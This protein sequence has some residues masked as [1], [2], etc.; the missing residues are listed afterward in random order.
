MSKC[1]VTNKVR[2]RDE[3]A[4]RE[5]LADCRN[6]NRDRVPERYYKCPHC[7]GYHLT[8]QY[9]RTGTDAKKVWNPGF[10]R[11]LLK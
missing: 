7:D 2:Y 11:F 9:H 5:G 3:A 6:R 8:S 1:A 4:A 10:L